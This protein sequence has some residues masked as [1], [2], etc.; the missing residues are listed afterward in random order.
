VLAKDPDDYRA[1]VALS[2]A[3]RGIGNFHEALGNARR[4]AVLQPGA[5]PAI[6]EV[7][8][9]RN[10]LGDPYGALGAFENLTDPGHVNADFHAQLGD[11]YRGLEN[12]P[13]ALAHYRAALAADPGSGHAI[14]AL[15]SLHGAA[16]DAR[17][18]AAL[19][20]S[21][22]SAIDGDFVCVYWLGIEA[23]NRGDLGAAKRLF[24]RTHVVARESGETI[25]KLPWPVPEPRIRHDYEQ[26]ELLARRG[27]LDA[28]GNAALA[29][30]ERHLRAQESPERALLPSQP[31]AEALKDALCT[32]F[33]IPDPA[34]SGTA[35][36]PNDYDAIART[37]EKERIV[38]ID[39]FLSPAALAALAIAKAGNTKGDDVR[40]G[41]YKIERYEGLI[42][43]YV[44][45]FTADVHDAVTENDYVWAQF[46]DNRILPVGTPN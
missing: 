1:L 37:Y 26:L 22:G 14:R 46:I 45:P 44:K 17:E 7:M 32:E 11:A 30:L 9:C 13:Q 28:A 10:K 6:L 25:R 38:V 15:V 3:N 35:L 8:R 21:H 16:G 33:S 24:D 4:A 29:T 31:E 12:T 36:G 27:R 23:L 43:T 2:V 40:Q 18:L 5:P 41:F 42:K 34:F 20:E 39:N 19:R